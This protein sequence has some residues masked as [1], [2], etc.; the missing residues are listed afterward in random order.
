VAAADRVVA[1]ARHVGDGHH[2]A[3]VDELYAG[4]PAGE[5]ACVVVPDQRLD[6]DDVIDFQTGSGVEQGLAHSPFSSSSGIS[7][8][9]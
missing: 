4:D 2:Q 1:V 6:L 3:A 5:P 7:K 9:V 8:L